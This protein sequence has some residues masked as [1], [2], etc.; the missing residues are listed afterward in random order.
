MANRLFFYRLHNPYV[1]EIIVTNYLIKFV[2]IYRKLVLVGCVTD[3][4]INLHNTFKFVSVCI[5]RIC[6]SIDDLIQI[7]DIANIKDTH[8]THI[9]NIKYA[10]IHTVTVYLFHLCLIR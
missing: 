5:T 10:C 1:K 9:G 6:S 8:N 2:E 4:T 7:I 3:K